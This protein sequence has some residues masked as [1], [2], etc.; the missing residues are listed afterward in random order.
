MFIDFYNQKVKNQ[1]TYLYYNQFTLYDYKNGIYQGEYKKSLRDGLGVFYWNEGQMYIGQW[2]QDF[3]QGQGTLYF[4]YEGNFVGFFKE[5]RANG[6]GIVTLPNE[7]RYAGNWEMGKLVEIAAKYDPIK[8]RWMP[9]KYIG[10]QFMELKMN[11]GQIIAE[12]IYKNAKQVIYESTLNKQQNRPISSNEVDIY[13]IKLLQLDKKLYYHGIA[14]G[15]RP[16]GLGLMFHIEG[17][18]SVRGKFSNK[19]LS[20][21]GKIEL[22]NGEIYDG[23]FLNGIFQNGAYYNAKDNVYLLGDFQDENDV[24]IIEKGQGY[25]YEQ[26]L[27]NKC[28]I[29]P[30]H[31]IYKSTNSVVLFLP[32]ED[33]NRIRIFN[34]RKYLSEQNEEQNYLNKSNNNGYNYIDSA[35]QE[36]V[37]QNSEKFSGYKQIKEQEFTIT[38]FQKL[39]FDKQQQKGNQNL[40]NLSKIQNYDQVQNDFEQMHNNQGEN[41]NLNKNN[42]DKNSEQY[43]FDEEENKQN[44]FEYD[45]DDID[46]LFFQ[47]QNLSNEKDKKNF[48]FSNYKDEISNIEHS[49]ILNQKNQEISSNQIL[50]SQWL[51]LNNLNENS[52]QDLQKSNNQKQKL[53]DSKRLD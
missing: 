18:F 30:Q 7:V 25:P 29:Y 38:N 27:N 53:Q 34:R 6:P 50:S 10:G 15:T 36:Q 28:G 11:N 44:N 9:V 40:H 45:D 21:P 42:I 17:N 4:P 3:M 20:G 22:E 41:Q 16:D 43:T 51:N 52:K 13:Q 19:K 14:R 47:K 35:Q 32:E 26:I 8:M 31:P 24:Q 48:S 1:K 37:Y 12:N 39:Y 23:Q 49:P 2:S 5:N 46:N 33:R